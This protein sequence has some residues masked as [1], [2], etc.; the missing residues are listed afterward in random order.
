MQ[1]SKTSFGFCNNL[2]LRPRLLPNPTSVF[3][4]CTNTSNSLFISILHP[5]SDGLVRSVLVETRTSSFVRPISKVV[6]LECDSP[7][8]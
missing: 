2:G 7:V 3:D 1:I 8:Y 5:G 4:I 6:L